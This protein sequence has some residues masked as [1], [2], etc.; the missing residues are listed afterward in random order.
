MV[1]D[2][3][4]FQP[5]MSVSCCG[6][7]VRSRAPYSCAIGIA[8]AQSAPENVT[9]RMPPSGPRTTSQRVPTIDGRDVELVGA[10]PVTVLCDGPVGVELLGG[11]DVLP[12]P[13]PSE[14]VEEAVVPSPE[15]AATT[16]ATPRAAAAPT[17]RWVAVDL[18]RSP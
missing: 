4:H 11:A 3:P 6:R 16:N 1:C 9:I 14:G 12:S 8:A 2:G 13:A 15:Q 7:P 10:L 18:T 17:V 5:L